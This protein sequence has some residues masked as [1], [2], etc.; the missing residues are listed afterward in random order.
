MTGDAGL[1]SDR[2]D[3]AVAVAAEAGELI[4]R[5]YHDAELTVEHKRDDSPVTAADREAEQLIRR[6]LAETW[7]GDGVLGE[8]FAETPGTSGYRW[9]LDPVDGTKSFIHHVP[10]FGTLV[11]LEHDG[12]MVAGLCRMPALDEVVYAAI[13]LGAWWQQGSEDPRP[14]RVSKVSRL[15]EALFCTTTITGW[16]T[17]GRQD[18]FDRLCQA[19]GLVR[20]WS[21]CY[22]HLL[23][24]T[25]RADVMVDPE[26]NAWDAA[27]LLPIMLEAGG[28]FVDLEGRS[29]IDGGH[30]LSVNAGLRDEVL[31]VISGKPG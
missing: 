14:A 31:S 29:V 20:G 16:R 25:G 13:G 9:I 17:T 7:P 2:L 22:G 11:G 8:E 1:L 26:M 30:G 5:H 4:M 10:L 3:F 12:R 28:H 24:A 21:D 19:A 23:V 27:A 15:S 18:V 6:R